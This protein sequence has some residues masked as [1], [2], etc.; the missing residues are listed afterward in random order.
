M[1]ILKLV[2]VM[3]TSGKNTGTKDKVIYQA[4][5]EKEEDN[6]INLQGD[7]S[8]IERDFEV[9]LLGEVQI[10]SLGVED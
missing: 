5:T 8:Y 3:D 10:P 1:L 7:Y 4:L 9:E 6:L 2:K